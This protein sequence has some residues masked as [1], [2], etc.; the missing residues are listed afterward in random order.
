VALD[1]AGNALLAGFTNSSNFT[2]VNP[3]QPTIGSTVTYDAFV[4]KVLNTPAAP[5]FTSVSPDTGTSSSDQITNPAVVSGTTLTLNGTATPSSTVTVYQAGVAANIGSTTASGAGAW[6]LT[7]SP[8][9]PQGVYAYTA[10]ATLGG[11]TGPLSSPPFVVVVDTTAPQVV[12]TPPPAPIYSLGPVIRV[13]ATDNVGLPSGY[14]LA[15]VTLDVD[16]NHDGIIGNDPG[17]IGYS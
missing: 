3:L 8:T 4:A 10:T 7:L 1:P 12:A 14:P 11:L 6:S 17:E 15:T 13:S 16:T 2:T 5:V 9:P